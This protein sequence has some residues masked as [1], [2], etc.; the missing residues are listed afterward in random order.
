M[1]LDFIITLFEEAELSTRTA[2]EGQDNG[3]GFC[4]VIFVIRIRTQ[5]STLF[6]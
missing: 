4:V 6:V 3:F 5:E 2:S 1:L